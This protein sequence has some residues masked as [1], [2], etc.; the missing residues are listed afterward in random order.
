MT[1]PGKKIDNLVRPTVLVTGSSGLIGKVVA[2]RLSRQ[3]KVIG[4]DLVDGEFTNVLGDIRDTHLL[5]G[6]MQG[7]DCVFHLAAL[8][9]PHVDV[10]TRSEF[11]DV[12]VNGTDALLESARKNQVPRFVLTSTT[13]VYG[14]TTR[15]KSSAIWVTEDLEPFSEDIY[16]ETKLEAER[17]CRSAADDSL[18]CA[19]LRMSRC[20]PEPENL[21]VFYRLYRGVDSRDVAEANYLAMHADLNRF[22][23]FNISAEPPF[24]ESDCDE[25]FEDSLSTI[26]KYYPGSKN[27]FDQNGWSMPQCIDRVYVVD[28]AK[29]MLGYSPQ[30]SFEYLTGLHLQTC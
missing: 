14:C 24:K 5:N 18:T 29:T 26:E 6:V 25:L 1:T 3:A 30:F 9:T 2:K 23:I 28:K 12:N 11:Y 8:L 17:L 13:S 16:D 10:K 22:E 20:F 7:V 19:V 27:L 21:L 15:P 4:I